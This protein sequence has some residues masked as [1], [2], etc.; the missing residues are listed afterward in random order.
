MSLVKSYDEQS[1]VAAGY[2][3]EG[4][5]PELPHVCCGFS[6]PSVNWGDSKFRAAGC[7]QNSGAVLLR[8]SA[9][10]CGLTACNMCIQGGAPVLLY[11]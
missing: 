7:K 11:L 9:L 10:F 1:F 8:A 2:R 3:P 6:H 4:S 5:R